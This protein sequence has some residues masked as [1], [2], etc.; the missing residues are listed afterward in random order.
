MTA[1]SI[2]TEFGARKLVAEN[3][4]LQNLVVENNV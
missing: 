1:A 4:V 2:V 3:L